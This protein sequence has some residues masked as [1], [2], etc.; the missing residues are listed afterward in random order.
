MVLD[1][2][3]RATNPPSMVDDG[4][5]KPMLMFPIASP[6]NAWE[7]EHV[8]YRRRE[9][10]WSR[11]PVASLNNTWSANWL[12][13]RD[14][15]IDALLTR[16]P[17]DGSLLPYGGGQVE[18]W[19]SSDGGDTWQRDGVF[20]PDEDLICNNPRPVS[21]SH[22]GQLENSYTVFGWEGPHG[23]TKESGLNKG[24]AFL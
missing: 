8:F 14:D 4:T 9:D 22:G 11:T 21:T 7:G 3:R 17:A 6:E 5:G 16:G 23:L 2:D 15:R 13:P 19:H 12:I 18:R 20:M 10:R 24:Q 1:S